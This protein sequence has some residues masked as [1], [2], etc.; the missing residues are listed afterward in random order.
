MTMTFNK[1]C[2]CEEDI[3]PKYLL[4]ERKGILYKTDERR[5]KGSN[6]SEEI[7]CVR[8][9]CVCFCKDSNANVKSPWGFNDKELHFKEDSGLVLW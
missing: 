1:F 8:I 2:S 5:K 4:A 3:S 6:S 9:F 7:D